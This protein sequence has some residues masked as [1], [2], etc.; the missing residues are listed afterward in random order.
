MD[1]YMGRWMDGWVNRQMDDWMDGW[2]GEQMDGGWM[3]GW[4]DKRW[5]DGQ[6]LPGGLCSAFHG[7]SL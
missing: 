5:L 6:M 1:G 3:S 4:R 2:T 7:A